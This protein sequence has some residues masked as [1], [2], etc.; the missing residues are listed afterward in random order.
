VATARQYG[1]YPHALAGLVGRLAYRLGW[2]FTLR[3]M[4]RDHADTHGAAAGGLTLV[5]Y[6]DVHD[7]Y[8]PA[9]RRPVNHYFPVPAA[10]YN[11]ASWLRWLLGCVLLVEQHEACEWFRLGDGDGDVRPFSPTHGPGENLYSI[12][13]LATDEER[14][15]SFRGTR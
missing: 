5:V 4:E 6:A 10:T 12:K 1:P 11:E 7:A 8:E 2:T 3:D 13:E 14:R 15:T 9:R